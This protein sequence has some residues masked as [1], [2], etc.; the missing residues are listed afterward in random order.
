VV[1]TKLFDYLGAGRPVVLAMEDGEAADILR[2]SNAGH[3]VPPGD[4]EELARAI[5]DI[6][7]HPEKQRHMGEAGRKYVVR[8]HDVRT[9]AGRFREALLD[10]SRGGRPNLNGE[11]SRKDEIPGWERVPIRRVVPPA[12]RPEVEHRP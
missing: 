8:H 5:L 10:V 7:D 2:K 4:P 9:F 3:V 12:A 6:A 11:G 1:P